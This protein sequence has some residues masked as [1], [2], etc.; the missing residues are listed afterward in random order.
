M[1]NNDERLVKVLSSLYESV[2]CP[3]C[4]T[5]LRLGDL[6]CP[7]CGLD[8]DEPFRQWAEMLLQKLDA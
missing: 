4:G 3:E 8:T 5:R 6:D 2:S 1:L 7:H